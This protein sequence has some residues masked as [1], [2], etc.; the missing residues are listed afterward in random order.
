MAS[1]TL[2]GQE[3]H[4]SGNLPKI[5]SLAPG[6]TLTKQNLTNASLSDFK[7]K[8][9]VLNIFPS[10]DT[11]TCAASVRAFNKVATDLDNTV[12]LCIS[13]DLPFAHKRFC[14]VEGIKNVITLSDFKNNNFSDAYQN[15]IVDGPMTGLLSRTIVI[16][17]ESG[18]VT[19]TEQVPEIGQE[20]DYDA[21]LASLE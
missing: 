2:K 21:T 20:P 11:G 4:T 15:I 10:L 7:G 18:N 8:K 13:K 1:I 3:I 19:Y 16:I 17:N 6:F 5:G 14:E 9:I 12:V